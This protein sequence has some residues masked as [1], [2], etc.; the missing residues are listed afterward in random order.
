[1]VTI[2]IVPSQ[3][4]SLNVV[5]INPNTTTFYG[6]DCRHLVLLSNYTFEAQVHASLLYKVNIGES[7]NKG[8]LIVSR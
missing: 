3:I 2:A 8:A 5:A 4:E 7:E 6:L 1:M